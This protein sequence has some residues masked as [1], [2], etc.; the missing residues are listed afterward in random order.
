MFSKINQEFAH[1]AKAFQ[2]VLFAI[3][4]VPFI[5]I[6][7]NANF[8]AP[9]GAPENPDVVGTING[10]EVSWEVYEEEAINYLISSSM[11]FDFQRTKP[12][13]FAVLQ[14]GR[15][16]IN[17]P[18]LYSQVMSYK[19][20]WE[21]VQKAGFDPKEISSSDI[22]DYI[23]TNLGQNLQFMAMIQRTKQTITAQQALKGLRNA[24]A[25]SGKRID[26]AVKR[27][28]TIERFEA[29]LKKKA[30]VSD[31]E[32]ATFIKD[33]E[34]SY[35][36]RSLLIE[37]K[38]YENAPLKKHYEANKDKYRDDNAVNAHLVTLYKEKY[39]AKV[40]KMDLTAE[41]EKLYNEDTKA[42]KTPA[43]T[44]SIK[45]AIKSKLIVKKAQEMAAKDAK[46][47]YDSFAKQ[48]AVKPEADV[49]L[50]TFKKLAALQELTVEES[51][52]QTEANLNVPTSDKEFVKAV[53]GLSSEKPAAMVKGRNNTYVLL[54]KTKGYFKPI[55]AVRSELLESFYN[56]NAQ[57]YYDT[58]KANYKTPHLLN[59][60]LVSFFGGMFIKAAEESLKGKLDDKVTEKYKST[61][62]Y[63]TAQRKLI[64][65]KKTIKAG[66]TSEEKKAA[67]KV[68]QDFITSLNGKSAAEVSSAI[69]P[70][71]SGIVIQPQ[72]W[73]SDNSFGAEMKKEA[74]TIDKGKFTKISTQTTHTSALY[75]SDTRAKTPQA[76]V[77]P[78]LRSSIKARK[79]EE[80]ANEAA[81]KFYE[82]L[83]TLKDP[84]PESIKKSVDEYLA[85]NKIAI[86]AYKEIK[87]IRAYDSSNTDPRYQ[88]FQQQSAQR[89]AQANQIDPSLAAELVQLNTG[90]LFT[91]V[92][93]QTQNPRK[94]VAFLVKD[95]LPATNPFEKVKS[96]IYATLNSEDAETEASKEAT[97]IKLELEKSLADSKALNNLLGK[98]NFKEAVTEKFKALKPEVSPLLKEVVK[99][100]VLNSSSEGS[101]NRIVYVETI[102]EVSKEEIAKVTKEH[103]DALTKKAEEKEVTDFWSKVEKANVIKATKPEVA[104][105]S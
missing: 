50:K 27:E 24:L 15:S 28:I 49:L 80:L 64:L 104:K 82:F 53:I 17:S 45:A 81:K 67:E 105:E 51:G 97:N 6:L 3:I 84:T 58:N 26:D 55:S 73:S 52:F 32:L 19:V 14:Y 48:V 61:P 72:G 25:I 16:V 12:S 44:D 36:Y 5:F 95:I 18:N 42:N 68:L 100:N 9:G 20:R 60:G 102:T 31:A 8:S 70:I 63:H 85:T 56:E 76:E 38:D 90:N 65:F 11:K 103:K 22:R 86:T 88:Q 91:R 4:I 69:V 23:T 30:K 37:P 34:R 92:R 39:E 83:K 35:K 40:A 33:Q 98:Y 71:K 10:Q 78:Q 77:D 96:S 74:F 46:K 13:L 59:T 54:F 66:A 87:D 21:E 29:D 75:V 93:T 43:T 1:H 101:T 79:S 47:L 99:N 2:F 62:E 57:K 94:V 89:L 7:P 41:V